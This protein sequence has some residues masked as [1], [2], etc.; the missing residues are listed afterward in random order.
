MKFCK[1]LFVGIVALLVSNT[2]YS[3]NTLIFDGEVQMCDGV[4]VD[5]GDGGP[6]TESDYTFTICPNG[7]FPSGFALI[8]FNFSG[9]TAF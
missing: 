6:Y 7:R 9:V 8:A 5:D 4:F 2:F 3:Q 1:T